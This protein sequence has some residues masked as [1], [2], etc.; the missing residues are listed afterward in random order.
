M[1]VLVIP[2]LVSHQLQ[3]Y[4]KKLKKNWKQNLRNNPPQKK[5]HVH[6]HM[7][8]SCNGVSYHVRGQ[9]RAA[10]KRT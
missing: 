6:A 5:I 1:F 7:K 4:P 2:R 9:V 3:L 10:P 8:T